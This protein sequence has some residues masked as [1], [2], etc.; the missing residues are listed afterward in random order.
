MNHTQKRTG[1]L[2]S[3]RVTRLDYFQLV[4]NIWERVLNSGNAYL[5]HGIY[6]DNCPSALSFNFHRILL[7]DLKMKC[8]QLIIWKNNS[9]STVEQLIVLLLD[10]FSILVM[11]PSMIQHFVISWLWIQSD[12]AP[13]QYKNKNSF[14]ISTKLPKE[15]KLR[16]ICKYGHGK[17]AID[18]IPVLALKILYK[19]IS[20]HMISFSMYSFNYK[21]LPREDVVTSRIIQNSTKIIFD[22]MKQHLM[23]FTRKRSFLSQEVSVLMQFVPSIEFV[24]IMFGGDW[25][26]LFWYPLWLW[27]WRF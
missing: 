21:N 7:C 20:S 4:K 11:A 25:T 26:T 10:I 22:C 2:Q 8:N 5:K 6:V 27:F 16:K 18:G 3:T 15:F 13:T 14:F 23:V 12:N 9:L 24:E 1:L 19:K 17:G